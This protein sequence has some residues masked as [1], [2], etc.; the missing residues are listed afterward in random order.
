MVFG[1]ERVD[2]NSREVSIKLIGRGSQVYLWDMLWYENLLSSRTANPESCFV[3]VDYISPLDLVFV[4]SPVV[5]FKPLSDLFLDLC[6]D[7]NLSQWFGLNIMKPTCFLL[8]WELGYAWRQGI[9]SWTMFDCIND[10]V[11]KLKGRLKVVADE[12][13]DKRM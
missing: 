9:E 3:K 5:V 13:T 6:C 12:V 10:V 2:L 4:Y 11:E 8:L 1:A 7:S